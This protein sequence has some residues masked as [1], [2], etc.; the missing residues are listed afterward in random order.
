MAARAAFGL[1]AVVVIF[2]DAT[3][4]A[5]LGAQFGL[6]HGAEVEVAGT[7]QHH[8]DDGEQ[9]VEVPGYGRHKGRQIAFK[10]ARGLQVAAD[11][12]GPA[13]NGGD[14]ADGCGGG[15][16]DVGQLGAGN[17]VAVRDRAHDSAHGKAV[18]IV[19][20]ENERAKGAGGEE[21]AGFP[22]DAPG[23]PRAIGAGAT[24][25]RDDV[26]QRPQQGTEDDDIEIDLFDH[27]GKRRF[28]GAD[29]NEVLSHTDGIDERSAQNAD[30]EGGK[31]F[32]C[33]EGQRDGD[34]G[35][36]QGKRARIERIHRNDSGKG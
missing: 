18:E 23:C 1:S 29:D 28:N 35:R 15:V 9:G 34:D 5:A 7:D 4:V 30:H 16:N 8:H 6:A 26:D 12:G 21:G 27:D 36:Q 24:G 10:G 20:N 33:P 19:V 11:G 32:L 14:D 31:N 25:Q 22:L 2:F 17:P 13:G 3:H